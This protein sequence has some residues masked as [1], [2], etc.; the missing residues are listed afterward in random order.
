MHKGHGRRLVIWIFV[1]DIDE[2]L[3]WL[4]CTDSQ[5]STD[6]AF[7]MIITRSPEVPYSNLTS[8][9]G[10]VPQPKPLSRGYHNP[11]AVHAP[12]K[13]PTSNHA[14]QSLYKK[15]SRFLY[16]NYFCQTYRLCQK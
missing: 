7:R 16:A 2:M 8:H 14:S 12:T 3:C 11:N 1:L 9:E 5:D 6:D 10:H 13:N 15:F 4:D